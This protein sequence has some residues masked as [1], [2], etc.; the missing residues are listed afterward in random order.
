MFIQIDTYYVM[1]ENQYS[2]VPM[3]LREKRG[4]FPEFK[5]EKTTKFKTTPK[6]TGANS[7]IYEEYI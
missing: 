6:K 3:S 1:A 2:H 4:V 5:F 7:K